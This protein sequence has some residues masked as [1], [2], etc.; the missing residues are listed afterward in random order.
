[1]LTS[2]SFG[3]SEAAD[4]SRVNCSSFDNGLRE[5]LGQGRGVTDQ[6]EYPLLINGPI[7]DGE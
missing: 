2:P 7:L 6:R 3:C 5:S 4:R 1:M